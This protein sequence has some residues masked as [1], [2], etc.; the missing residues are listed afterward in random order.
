MVEN[1]SEIAVPRLIAWEVTRRC[2]LRCQHC[3][4]AATDHAYEGE[5]TTQ[6]CMTLLENVASFAKPIMILTG[7]EPM[8]REDIYDI[9][10]HGH[11]L[12]LRMV[13]AVCG[14][15]LDDTSVDRLLQAGVQ[16]VS[17]SLDGPDAAS[18]D[19]FR[20]VSGAFDAALR[21]IEAAR[22][23]GLAFQI[24]TTVTCHNVA[25]LADI[26][27]LAEQLGAVTFNPFLLVPTGRGKQLADQELSPQQYEATLQWL[28]RQQPETGMA[29]RVTCAPHYQ[30]IIRQHQT[31]TDNT[32][33][34]VK[35]SDSP[36]AQRPTRQQMGQGCMGGKSFAFISHVGR[37]QICG[38]LEE[39]AGDLQAN[40]L[41][42]RAIWEE[43]ELFHQVR[44]V[45][46]YR[47]K[48][49]WCEYRRICGG[50]R[51]RAYAMTGDYLA[52]EPFCVYE[53]RTK[54][55]DRT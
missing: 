16:C 28:A 7:G 43:S 11:S 38:F 17:V 10:R 52:S 5:L 19:G 31:Q 50:C 12:G 4:A 2:T 18:H 54:Q 48:C 46:D 23:G 20:Q 24:N 8:L 55:N 40:G 1:N 30:R 21:G 9:A 42:F 44:A 33:N 37:V 15:L 3:R 39:P 27:H 26:M 32:G 45:D 53:P 29:V 13:I 36:S 34:T 14:A 25:Q 51:A 47:G 35:P 22:R 41:D 6:Q 49:G